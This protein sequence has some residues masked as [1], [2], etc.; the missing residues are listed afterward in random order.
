MQ[1]DWE[2]TEQLEGSCDLR[3]SLKRVLTPQG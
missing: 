2:H 3:F 1:G